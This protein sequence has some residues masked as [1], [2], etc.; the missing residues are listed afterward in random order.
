MRA[1]IL[2]AGRGMRLQQAAAQQLP[3]ALLR[4]DG[5]TPEDRRRS[6]QM[7]LSRRSPRL[8]ATL[9]PWTQ[10]TLAGLLSGWTHLPRTDHGL[11]A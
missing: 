4:F 1:I 9:P 5:L 8:A 6:R 2:A 11:P 3:K 10:M 7:Y